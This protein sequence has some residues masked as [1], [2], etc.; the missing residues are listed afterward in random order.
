MY[1]TLRILKSYIEC[2]WRVDEKLRL[3]SEKFSYFYG[4]FFVIWN[5]FKKKLLYGFQYMFD[6]Y[7]KFTF[8][9]KLWHV[10]IIVKREK[11]IGSA[12]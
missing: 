8:S 12:S 4:N 11:T 3:L 2:V 9:Q 1:Y 5:D 7:S 6:R 10:F